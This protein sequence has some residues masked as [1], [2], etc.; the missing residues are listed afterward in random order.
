MTVTT[1]SFRA[2]FP[3]FKDSI[4]YPEEMLG[5]WL[6]VAAQLVNPG[7]WGDLTDLGVSLILAHSAVLSH[8]AAQRAAFGKAPGVTQGI[9]TSKA[10]D[11]VSAGYDVSTGSEEGAGNWNLTTYGARFYRMSKMMGMGPLQL[12]YEEGG[13]RPGAWS[14]PY[15]YSQ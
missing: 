12:G 14:G 4:R 15:F 10:V 9:L 7:R 5:F 8:Q 11:G 1:A 2:T 13:I 6:P 3:E